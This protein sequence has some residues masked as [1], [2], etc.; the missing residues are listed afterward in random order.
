MSAPLTESTIFAVS[1]LVDDAQSGKREPSHSDL[2]AQI[3]RAGLLPGDPKAQ[4]QLV[5]KAKRIRYILTWALDHNP[6]AGE[7]FIQSL[8]SLIRSCGG[9]RSASPNY[10]GAEAI[11]NAQEAFKA[12]SF[13]LTADGELQQYLAQNLSGAAMTA[14]LEAYVKRAQRGASTQPSLL[15][16][17]K[18]CSRLRP[19][20]FSWKKTVLIRRARISRVSWVW[21]S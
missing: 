5:G 12:E 15:V 18:I 21:R 1:R 14:A 7:R 8:I 4:G 20:I 13:L 16:R 11:A 6:D 3:A 17:G 2:E 9:F 19:H 10:V